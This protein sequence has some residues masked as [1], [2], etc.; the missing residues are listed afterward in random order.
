MFFRG[1]SMVNVKLSIPSHNIDKKKARLNDAASLDKMKRDII[2]AFSAKYKF[3][4]PDTYEIHIVPCGTT[5]PVM[6]CKLIN[7]DDLII[8]TQLNSGSSVEVDV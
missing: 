6:D 1:S 5:I 7:E 2:D 3:D 8:L 4:H